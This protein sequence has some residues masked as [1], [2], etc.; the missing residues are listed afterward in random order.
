MRSRVF[1][2]ILGLLAIVL[3]TV[4]GDTL[5]AFAISFI[6]TGN[7]STSPIDF[8]LDSLFLLRN[9]LLTF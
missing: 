4:E 1:A 9:R 6:V 8:V 7:T 2:L 3:E 5:A